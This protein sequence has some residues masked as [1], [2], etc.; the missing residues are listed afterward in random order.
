MF[1]TY[2]IVKHLKQMNNACKTA[3]V[4]NKTQQTLSNRLNGTMDAVENQ[5]INPIINLAT[6]CTEYYTYS[7][8]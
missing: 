5:L 1:H 7:E 8:Q 2:A 3:D 6:T 4:K